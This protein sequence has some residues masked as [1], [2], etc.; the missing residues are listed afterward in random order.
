MGIERDS[1]ELK[2]IEEEELFAGLLTLTEN[3]PGKASILLDKIKNE[4]VKAIRAQ[5][6]QSETPQLDAAIRETAKQE[7]LKC[8]EGD[9]KRE[10][11]L[12]RRRAQYALKKSMTRSDYHPDKRPQNT[13]AH[14]LVALT[15]PRARIALDILEKFGIPCDYAAN[16]VDLPRYVKNQNHKDMPDAI[17]GKLVK[18]HFVRT[19]NNKVDEFMTYTLDNCIPTYYSFVATKRDGCVPVESLDLSYSALNISRTSSGE[20]NKSIEVVRNG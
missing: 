15:D 11:N 18:I 16:G 9:L 3:N 2:L 7:T 12:A 20:N 19:G 5:I 4:T 6:K 1:I 13:A 17:A 8:F 10:L 14:H